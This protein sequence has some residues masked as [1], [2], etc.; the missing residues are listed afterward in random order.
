MSTSRF[1]HELENR[2]LSQLN[3]ILLNFIPGTFYNYFIF[4]HLVVICGNKFLIFN[5]NSCSF[6]EACSVRP[7]MY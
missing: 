6:K 4:S 3:W 7:N 1:D 5:N 2:D